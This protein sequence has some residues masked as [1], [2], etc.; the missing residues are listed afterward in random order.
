[1]WKKELSSCNTDVIFRKRIVDDVCTSLPTTDTIQHFLS[2][3]NSIETTIKFTVEVENENRIS[4]LDA[5]I[6]H[7][8][9]GSLSTAVNRKKTHTEKIWHMIPTIQLHIK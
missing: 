7:H 8:S 5:D 2:H 1:M 6:M 9:D 4:F 3:L